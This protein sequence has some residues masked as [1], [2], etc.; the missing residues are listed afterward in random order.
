MVIA[1]RKRLNLKNPLFAA[2]KK[3][4]LMLHIQTFIIFHTIIKR[5]V[6]KQRSTRNRSC[7]CLKAGP[8]VASSGTDKQ[9]FGI[10]TFP[11]INGYKLYLSTFTLSGKMDT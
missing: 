9:I 5:R 6:G 4:Y 3:N 2:E 7:S 1:S 8:S 10:A 11:A